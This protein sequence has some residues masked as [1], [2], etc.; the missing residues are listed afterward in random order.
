MTLWP[1]VITVFYAIVVAL[2]AYAAA[3]WEQPLDHV[4]KADVI[5]AVAFPRPSGYCDGGPSPLRAQ[6]SSSD[7]PPREGLHRRHVLQQR[8]C[9]STLVRRDRQTHPLSWHGTSSAPVPHILSPRV[10]ANVY[11]SIV[12]SNSGD[13][14]PELLR[15]FDARLH[16][17]GVARR[18]LVGDN[19]IPRPADMS[20]AQPR[21]EFL[22]AVR[23][24]VLAPLVT[25]GGYERVLFSNDVFLTAESAVELLRTN[26][27][28]YDMACALDFHSWG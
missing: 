16:S 24:L 12:E 23:N 4:Y 7:A 1:R 25:H 27:G 9:P 18:V 15:A 8:A 13:R 19:S 21:I 14:T 10:Q 28:A 5:K 11:V 17:L 6:T 2:G 20:T 22:A 3:T 26:G